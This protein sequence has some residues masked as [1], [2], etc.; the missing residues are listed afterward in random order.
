MITAAAKRRRMRWLP[1]FAL[2]AVAVIGLTWVLAT[3]LSNDA[4]TPGIQS[5]TLGPDNGQQVQDYLHAARATLEE[6]DPAGAGPEAQ[7]WA[8]VSFGAA[9]A[10]EAAARIVD[11]AGVPRIAQVLVN[12]PVD[13]VAM[14]VVTGP[15][16]LPT[17]GE[18]D[19]EAALGRAVDNAL[20]LAAMPNG[21]PGAGNVADQAAQEATQQDA[22][23]VRDRSAALLEHTRSAAAA[24][25]GCV[26]GLIVRAD[27]PTLVQLASLGGDVRA[28]EALPSDA[29]AGRFAVR[30]LLPAYR[31]QV[32][33]LP[34]DGRLP[35]SPR[36]DQSA[37][38]GR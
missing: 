6:P 8:L 11:G 20:A 14:P 13:R 31:E 7:R 38:P 23:G 24:G 25:E 27:I 21:A 4:R 35:E 22:T 18:T 9:L 12:T 15:V 5:D 17:A 2:V 1:V 33:P 16:T 19:S 32:A 10:P 34:D 28:V 26:I 37:R 36:A 3:A 29:V 30:P